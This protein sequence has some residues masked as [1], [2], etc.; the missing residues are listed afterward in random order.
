[1]SL[2]S[3]PQAQSHGAVIAPIHLCYG[4]R[5]EHPTEI[6]VCSGCIFQD[7]T[8]VS[9]F[10]RTRK[11]K[12][13]PHLIKKLSLGKSTMPK[14][15]RCHCRKTFNRGDACRMPFSQLSIVVSPRVG[16]VYI[17]DATFWENLLEM[18]KYS[19]LLNTWTKASTKAFQEYTS[20]G[21]PFREGS[22][23]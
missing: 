8:S 19:W 16:S 7:P 23:K 17:W 6:A 15:Q 14:S 22:R 1:M 10:Y 9:A 13:G 2:G 5:I 21:F 11:T 20:S 4:V 18:T 3:I 12:Q